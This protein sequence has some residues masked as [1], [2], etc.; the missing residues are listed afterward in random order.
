MKQYNELHCIGLHQTGDE[1]SKSVLSILDT[2][3]NYI[4]KAMQTDDHLFA[5]VGYYNTFHHNV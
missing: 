3:V 4:R 1:Q 2:T 5:E